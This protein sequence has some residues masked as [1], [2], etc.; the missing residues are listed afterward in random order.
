MRTFRTDPSGYHKV[1]VKC[2]VC[3]FEDM[4]TDASLW[5]CLEC[6]LRGETNGKASSVGNVERVGVAAGIT[7]RVVFSGVRRDGAAPNS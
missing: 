2:K 3:G 7:R 5:S 6:E 4:C 1:A